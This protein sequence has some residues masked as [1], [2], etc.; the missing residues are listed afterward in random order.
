[1]K[2]Q[3]WE[4]YEDFQ[5]DEGARGGFIKSKSRDNRQRDR[6]K[7]R[8]RIAR[9]ANTFKDRDWQEFDNA[10]LEMCREEVSAWE[11]QYVTSQPAPPPKA[12]RTEPKWQPTSP[13]APKKMTPSQPPVDPQQPTKAFSGIVF[14]PNTH[15]IKGNQIDFDR[16]VSIEK[17]ENTHNDRLTFGIKFTFVGKKG[18]SRIAWFNQNVRERDAAFDAEYAFWCALKENLE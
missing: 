18:A 14:G 3:H 8:R 13:P 16:V 5:D 7:E 6:E 15:T 12:V 11:K 4:D 9:S 10:D 2:K 17:V 1:M